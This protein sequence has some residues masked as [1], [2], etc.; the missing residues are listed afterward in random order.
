MSNRVARH[1]YAEA[2]WW[3][4]FFEHLRCFF[5]NKRDLRRIA[6]TPVKTANIRRNR[7]ADIEMQ[8]KRKSEIGVYIGSSYLHAASRVI[9]V[10]TVNNLYAC[11]TRGK[12]DA[13]SENYAIRLNVVRWCLLLQWNF[14]DGGKKFPI[15][16][17]LRSHHLH[18]L[19][20]MFVSYVF[21][22]A[23]QTSILK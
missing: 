3:S 16:S 11:V 8:I 7:E 23:I 14:T 19:I 17:L 20:C 6:H 12:Y 10:H 18:V 1:H 4:V 5:N 9:R 21:I 2:I 13:S 22:F 15:V